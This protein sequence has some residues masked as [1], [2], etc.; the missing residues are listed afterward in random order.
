[1]ALN[2]FKRYVTIVFTDE[3]EVDQGNLNKLN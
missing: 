3:L 2:D 1:M